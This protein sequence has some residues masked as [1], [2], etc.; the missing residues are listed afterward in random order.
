MAFYSGLDGQLYLGPDKIGKVQNWSL[1]AS[2]AVLE[3]TSLEDT[4][5]TLVNGVRSMSGSCRVFYYTTGTGGGTSDASKFIDNIIKTGGSGIDDGVDPIT[6][7][8]SASVTFKLH[9]DANKYIEVYAWITGVSMNM[10]VG[11]VMSVDVSFEVS[12]RAIQSTLV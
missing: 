1:N 6:P 11:E 9:A 2:Q 10:A 8:Q 3:T 4:D 12:G 7:Q 5:R